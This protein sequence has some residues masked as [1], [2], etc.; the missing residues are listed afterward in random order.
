MSNYGIDDIESLSFKEGVRARIPMYLGTDDTEGI[1]QALKE[2]INNSTDEALMGFGDV[3]TIIVDEKTGFVSVEDE[4][5][6]IPFGIRENGENVLVSIFSKSHTG[7]KFNNKNYTTVSGLNGIGIKATC[8]SSEEFY[9]TSYRDGKKASV[10]FKQGE[11]LSYKEDK[12][13]HK[14]GTFVKFKPDK[15]VFKNMTEGFTYN[16]ICENIKVISYL[17]KGVKF[18]VK[19]KETKDEKIYCSENGIADFIKDNISKPLMRTPIIC[20]AKD[21]TDEVEIAFMWTGGSE[22]SYVFVNGLICEQGGSPIT[23]AKTTITT[24]IKRLAKK[25]FEPELIRKG[26]VYAINCKVANPS[27]ANQTK[28]KINNPN[29]RTL[30]SQAFKQGLEEFSNSPD[31]TPIIEMMVKYQKAEK[32][33]DKARNAI[34]AH[35]KEMADIRKNKLAFI[36]K[37]SDAENL[38]QDAILCIVEGDSAGSSVAMG[39]DTKKYGILRIRGKMKNGLKAED[40][41]LYKNEEIKLLLYAL[42]IDINSYHADKLRYGKVAICVDP[43]SDGFHIALLIMANLHKLCPNFLKENR[44]FW[45]R[46]PLFIEQDKNNNPVSWYYTDEEFNKVRGK[47]K[48]NIKRIKGLGALS[49]KDLKATLFSTTGGQVMDEIRYS[50]EG[51][52]QLC[53]L[54]GEDITPRRDFVMN[55]IDYS[56]YGDM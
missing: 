45:L 29:L 40:E 35:T 37:L 14:N 18:I 56:Q 21:D 53:A 3:I 25:D 55:R 49:E 15:K 26:L 46:S 54:M 22:T 32:A 1:Y 2:V 10:I 36:D 42:G 24:S 28:S 20:S 30:A 19:N 47:L 11:L 12:S 52:E 4:G 27:F 6:G 48:G 50:P 9:A 34:L 17:T 8:L 51:I 41:E 31:F 44:L 43:D 16:K 5:R 13:N 33:A 23:G 38:G 7:G 39:R